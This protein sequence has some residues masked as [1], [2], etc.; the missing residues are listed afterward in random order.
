MRRPPLPELRVLPAKI[1]QS[2]MMLDLV[3]GIPDGY[4]VAKEVNL[5]EVKNS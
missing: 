2:R 4:E 1:G 3:S 5:K